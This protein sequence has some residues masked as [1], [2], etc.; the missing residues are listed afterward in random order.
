MSKHFTLPREGGLIEKN[1]PK[2]ILHSYE[3]IWTEIYPESRPASLA[4]ADIM[5]CIGRDEAVRRFRYLCGKQ[6]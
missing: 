1:L 3:N 4:I 6:A 5:H 2:G